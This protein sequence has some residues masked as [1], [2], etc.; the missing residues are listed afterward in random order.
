MNNDVTLKQSDS[1]S[2]FLHEKKTSLI[3]MLGEDKVDAFIKNTLLF[4]ANADSKLKE[5]SKE[6]IYQC[7]LTATLI[8]L[9]INK[10]LGLCWIIPYKGSATFQI[11]YKGYISLARRA[12]FT[13]LDTAIIYEENITADTFKTIGIYRFDR[14]NQ[15][16]LE[17]KN[18]KKIAGY[19]ARIKQGVFTFENFIT[20][21]EM[22]NHA[23]KY[24]ISYKSDKINSIWGKNFDE[25]ARKTILKL[26]LSKCGIDDKY[27]AMATMA[28]MAEIKDITHQEFEYLDN[29]TTPQS[30]KQEIDPIIDETKTLPPAPKN[31]T[32]EMFSN[33]VSY[34]AKST[35]DEVKIQLAE[36]ASARIADEK[37]SSKMLSYLTE[38]ELL[39]EH[40]PVSASRVS[41]YKDFINSIT[42]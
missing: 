30:I 27:L 41:I 34:Y 21:Q 1:F 9:P 14:S 8:D 37:N 12:G 16:F 10:N 11:G 17:N 39:K 32:E 2:L 23:E 24:S 33:M 29:P 40:S 13:R 20:H 19:Y 4:M 25:M 6:S 3:E 36:I 22:K 7:L 35:D 15:L 42:K 18:D 26:S 31:F 28:D 38:L 5:C